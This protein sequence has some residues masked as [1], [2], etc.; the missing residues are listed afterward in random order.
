MT[1]DAVKRPKADQSAQESI[2]ASYA[3]CTGLSVILLNACRAC[4]IPAR[5]TGCPQW[6]DRSGNHSW[7]E[8]W[9]GQWIYEG[10]SSSDPRNRSW[11]GDK[12]KAATED[13]LVGGVWAVTTEPQADGAFFVLPWKPTDRSYPAVPLR[14]F[15][16]DDGMISFD[17]SRFSEEKAPVW[18]YYKGEPWYRLAPPVAKTVDLPASVLADMTVRLDSDKDAKLVPLVQ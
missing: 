7:I 5:F 18:L 3:S 11:V 12:V 16:L 6:T 1:Y 4:G 9:D 13:S 17:I 14:A 15:Y 8:F 10:A 2:A